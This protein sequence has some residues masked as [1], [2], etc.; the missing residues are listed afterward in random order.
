MG[1]F[2]W[3]SWQESPTQSL[4][5]GIETVFALIICI[6]GGDAP[7]QAWRNAA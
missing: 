4:M 3:S 5:R 1:E 2:L 6:I 7:D